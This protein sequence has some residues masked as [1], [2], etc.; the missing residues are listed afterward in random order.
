MSVM[1]RSAGPSARGS[2][3][4]LR[5]RLPAL[6]AGHAG[7]AAAARGALVVVN[8]SMRRQC[9]FPKNRRA[10]LRAGAPTRRDLRLR[11]SCLPMSYN[12]SVIYCHIRAASRRSCRLPAVGP[13]S[14]RDAWRSHSTT[15]AKRQHA[16]RRGFT[17]IELMITI[18]II[19]TFGCRLPLLPDYV[20]QQARRSLRA[21]GGLARED[22]QSYLDNRRY[23][24]RRPGT[25]GIPGGNTPG[26]G[27]EVRH[28]P[29]FLPNP[30][31]RAIR[32][33]RQPAARRGK[34][35]GIAF[36]VNQGNTKMT[37]VTAATPMS[38]KGYASSATCWVR[39]KPSTC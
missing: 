32:V 29:A 17:L 15:Q 33:L 35:S 10:A 16:L 6:V 14:L 19:A 27:L 3:P 25:C 7:A 28:S 30:M 13:G 21:P 5:P 31:R 26:A 18:A 37:N 22:E 24:A 9:G 36:T 2:R 11:I 39:K 34:L 38:D 1:I 4:R 20:T 8:H 23:N 12:S